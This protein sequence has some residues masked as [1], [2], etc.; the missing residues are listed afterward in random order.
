MSCIG[1]GGKRTK[2]LV[3]AQYACYLVV[4]GETQLVLH[5]MG[6]N[7]QE[8]A[9]DTFSGRTNS[10]QTWPTAMPKN[11]RYYEDARPTDLS[12]VINFNGGKSWLH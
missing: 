2:Q 10:N 4:S 6:K 7:T 9:N 8:Y 12:F 11:Y 1:P 3:V 5:K